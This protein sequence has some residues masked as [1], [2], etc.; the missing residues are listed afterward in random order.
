MAITEITVADTATFAD[1]HEFG[2]AGA[3]VRLRGVAR[4]V[5]DPQA[6]ANAGIVDLDKAPRNGRGLVEYATDYD[7]LWP[8][9][10][11]RG[12]GILVYDVPNRG[13]KRIFTLLDDVPANDPVRI[14]DP[15]TREDAG[16]GFC[17]GRGYALLW[18]GWDPGA[19]RANGG[20][21]ADFPPVL[22]Q[23][24]P[25]TRRIRDEFH[26]GTRSP[27]DGAVRR[28]SYAAASTEQPQAR[29]TVRD[30]ESDRRTE[31]P[32]EQW[33][34]VDERSIRLLPQGRGFAPVKIYELWYE[35]VGSKVLG[36]GFASVRDLVS[37]F[38]HGG[39]DSG[40]PEALRSGIGTIRHALGF[41][42]SQSG[43]FLRHF[44]ELGMNADEHGHRV[45]DGVFSH[46]AGAG[47]VFANHSFGMPGR[48]ATQHEDRLYPENW[49]PFSPAVATDPVSGRTGALLTGSATDPK[50]I[51][52]NSATEY[53]QKGAS[54]V[55]IAPDGR[56]DLELPANARAYL[57]AGTQ[58]GGRPGV[59]PRPGPCLNPRNPH[60]ATP[61]LRALFLALEEWVTHGIEPPPSLVP[62]LAA[63]TAVPSAAVHMPRV[64]GFAV[65][66]GGNRVAAPVDWIDPPETGPT[67]F[68]E[69]FVCAVDGDGNETAGIRLPSIAVP[70][71]TYTGWNLYRAQPDALADRDGSFI[72]FARTRAERE[73]ADDPR[74]SL[75]ERY[76][77]QQHYVEQV[78]AAAQALVEARMLLPLDAAAF[79]AAA[80]AGDLF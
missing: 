71:G 14:N 52:T 75:E 46:V 69:S 16:L 28:L 53:W 6:P 21:G 34:F 15:K 3:Y 42:V 64:R 12:S 20:L 25:I 45:F 44:L 2:D 60:S 31:I 66:A 40:L 24:R 4:G 29:L 22:E 47:K 63:N 33:E 67:R 77:T 61:A 49:F 70:I 36:I 27:G 8:Q 43:R 38:R 72:A 59:D 55:H 30:R 54:L 57:I 7:L 37:A 19:P 41:G 76:G 23:G 58:H 80:E 39:D 10:P 74:P 26:I 5:L 32:R 50:I 56:R 17:L 48:T 1:G 79:V 18:S 73:A 51:E 65:P 9:D 68:Y 13:A 11:S 78:M 35:A 62:S